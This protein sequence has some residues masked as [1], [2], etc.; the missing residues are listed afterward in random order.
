MSLS[1]IVEAQMTESKVE[2]HWIEVQMNKYNARILSIGK[3]PKTS[4]ANSEIITEPS[5]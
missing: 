1:Q 3:T 4:V 5:Q 2:I